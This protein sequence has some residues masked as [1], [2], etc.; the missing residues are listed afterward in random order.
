MDL[1]SDTGEIDWT[2]RIA[3]I[4][5]LRLK[6]RI[7]EADHTTPE[8]DMTVNFP[9]Y[10]QIIADSTVK[11][12]MN[13]EWQATLNDCTNVPNQRRERGF[14]ISLNT[15][16]N[17]SYSCGNSIQGAWVG[18]AAGAN[19][20]LG[21]RPQS[22]LSA[23][24]PNAASGVYTVASFHTHTPTTYRSAATMGPG[25]GNGPSGGDLNAD[26]SDNVAGVVYDYTANP[27]PPLHPKNSTAALFSSRNQRLLTAE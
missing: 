20:T 2:A 24:A 3:G 19:I 8:K 12:K 16:G 22:N 9:T 23:V 17:G 21:A 27:V 13:S 26:A 18:P 5:K 7:N 6:T 15:V 14:W 1:L 11:S 4:F 10:A 25:R